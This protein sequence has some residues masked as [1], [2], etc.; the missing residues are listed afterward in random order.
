[1][2]ISHATLRPKFSYLENRGASRQ[3]LMIDKQRIDLTTMITPFQVKTP[4]MRP[5][6]MPLKRQ[7]KYAKRLF[8]DPLHS[9]RSIAIC[10]YPSDLWAKRVALALFYR[11]V[12]AQS[13]R[14]GVM[15][16]PL[17][18]RVYSGFGDS[19]LTSSERP[20]FLVISN[21][22]VD[23]TNFKLEKARDLMER[24]ENI[25]RVIVATGCDPVTFLRTKLYFPIDACLYLG[26]PGKEMRYDDED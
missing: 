10:S 15:S 26:G 6:S 7:L 2:L 16:A 25:P 4:G 18:H 14:R 1:M 23:S 8:D 5:M 12:E 3:D 19:L 11:A 9:Y 22:T 13:K 17:W 24:H 20:S 21:L